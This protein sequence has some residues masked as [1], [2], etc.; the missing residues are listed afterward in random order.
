MLICEPPIRPSLSI[1][2]LLESVNN[3]HGG[4]EDSYDLDA[5]ISNPIEDGVIAFRDATHVW[6]NV[7]ALRTDAWLIEKHTP[8][9]LQ[10]PYLLMGCSDVVVSDEIVDPF[11]VLPGI[12]G[13]ADSAHLVCFS[14]RCLWCSSK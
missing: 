8:S 4:V 11:E 5:G 9:L 3:V 7:I 6:A 14:R 12:P 10:P 13:K 1:L 2:H